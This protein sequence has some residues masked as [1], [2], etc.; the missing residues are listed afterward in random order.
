M[1]AETAVRHWCERQGQ[2][3]AAIGCGRNFPHQHC[4]LK[5]NFGFIWLLRYK[6]RT[7]PSSKLFIIFILFDQ[8]HFQVLWGFFNAISDLHLTAG[9][10]WHS[11]L[12]LMWSSVMYMYNSLFDIFLCCLT[13]SEACVCSVFCLVTH[14]T[15]I[16]LR[17]RCNLV[18][19]PRL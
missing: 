16:Y 9:S 14:P 4:H 7:L 1:T 2:H 8:K 3:R 13:I 19:D 5:W 12:A 11:I 10:R 18:K 6:E 17:I 15:E